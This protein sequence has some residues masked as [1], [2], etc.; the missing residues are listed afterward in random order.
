MKKN[1][2]N[3]QSGAVR[4]VEQHRTRHSAELVRAT[5]RG[6][7]TDTFLR[8]E[9]RNPHGGPG[10]GWLGV[11]CRDCGRH[12]RIQPHAARASEAARER[13]RVKV[14]TDLL[15]RYRTGTITCADIADA[16][17]CDASTIP[18]V[19]RRHGVPVRHRGG[20]YRAGPIRA[21]LEVAA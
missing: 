21:R 14:P 10:S 7:G 3:P 11:T 2:L 4:W 19:L 18:R 9:R 13:K 12:T 1:G 15:E 5:C 8:V 20:A 16:L 6:C 17:G